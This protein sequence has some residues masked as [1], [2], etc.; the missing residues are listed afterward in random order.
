MPALRRIGAWLYGRPYLLLTLTA[1]FWGGNVVLGRSVA[2]HVPP[3]GLA[4]VRW[5]GAFA[6]LVGFAWPQLRRDWPMARRHLAVLGLLSLTGVTLYNTLAYYGLQYT[7]AINGLLLQSSSPVLIA[8]CTF[9]LYR[10]RLSL[11][12]A[13]G[14]LL[15]GLG[16]V[17]IV[18]GGELTRLAALRIND[19]DLWILLGLGVYALYSALL[20][21]RPPIHG[22]SFLTLTFGFG[23]LLLTPAFLWEVS[24]GFR[25]QPDLATALAC[26]YVAIFPSILA[27]F[28]F[29]RGV[30]LVGA[31]RAGPFFHLI[32]LFGAALAFVFLGEAPHPYHAAAFLL[33]VSGVVVATRR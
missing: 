17:L 29:N 9:L 26:L 27:Y 11:G 15:S 2:G 12:Q 4:F 6:I 31:N 1:L 5:S 18:T 33:I 16:V 25:L 14:I 8:V 20:R 23:A 32:P 7:Q 30:E 24:T 10:E 3:V 13:L 28:C 19:G 22:L 21:R